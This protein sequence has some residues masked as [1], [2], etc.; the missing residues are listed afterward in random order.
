VK[1]QR[2]KL[3]LALAIH[4]DKGCGI[5]QHFE[6]NGELGRVSH[7]AVLELKSFTATGGGIDLD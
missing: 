4:D 3:P 6:I 5:A 1:L 7:L 2:S